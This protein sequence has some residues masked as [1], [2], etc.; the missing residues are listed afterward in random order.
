MKEAGE[1]CFSS[2]STHVLDEARCEEGTSGVMH[3]SEQSTEQADVYGPWIVVKRR[4]NGTKPLRSV[5][6]SPWQNYGMNIR[7][8]DY[9][10]KGS[11][12]RAAM[13]D[14]LYRESKRK[15]SPQRFVDKAQF[16]SV[17]QSIGQEGKSQAQQS[18]TLM[19][20]SSDASHIDRSIIIPNSQ[21]LTSVKGKKGV[22]RKQTIYGDQGIA[23]K[24]QSS[25]RTGLDQPQVNPDLV[26]DEG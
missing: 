11:V 14:G 17:V 21:R 2:R 22:A 10:E 3:D 24:V 19:L 8:K 5:R 16:A 7:T 12:D 6:T 20:M 4:K 23:D 18:P 15:L 9:V 1:T 13:M 26:G 25:K